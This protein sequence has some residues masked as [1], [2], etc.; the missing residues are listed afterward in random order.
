MPGVLSKVAVATGQKVD[1]SVKQNWVVGL[2]VSAGNPDA[3]QA[4]CRASAFLLRFGAARALA[5]IVEVAQAIQFAAFN[6]D[7]GWI[8]IFRS[9]DETGRG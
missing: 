2:Q 1:G 6:D 3:F 8:G 5:S 7:G 9:Q 4:F